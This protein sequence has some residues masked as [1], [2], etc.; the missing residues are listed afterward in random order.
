MQTTYEAAPE[1][2]VALARYFRSRAPGWCAT[3][4]FRAINTA[5]HLLALAALAGCCFVAGAEYLVLAVPSG[6]VIGSSLFLRVGTVDV[7]EPPGGAEEPERRFAR[8]DSEGLTVGGR[9]VVESCRWLA[10]EAIDATEGQVFFILGEDAILG[11]PRRAFAGEAE[12]ATFVE[13]ARK[14]HRA[15]SGRTVVDR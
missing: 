10:V 13:T 9:H 6:L 1:D 2:G 8:I 14:Y 11:V 12:F 7:R 3:R 5:L 4:A 15:A